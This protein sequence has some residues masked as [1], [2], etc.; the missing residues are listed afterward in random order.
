MAEALFYAAA[1]GVALGIFFDLLR[2]P[3]L[4]LGDRFFIDF[5]FWIIST[6]I[7]FS[8]LLVFN[9]GA[10]RAIYFIFIFLGFAAVSLTLGTVT[11][12][13]HKKLAKKIKI[14]LKF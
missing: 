11:R 14:R 5:L 10:V 2:L 12:P 9:S 8:Y 4:I 1:V 7:V 3:R 6:F 13:F